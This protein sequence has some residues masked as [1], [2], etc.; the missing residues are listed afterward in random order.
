MAMSS[1]FSFPNPLIF[2]QDKCKRR[3]QCA[4]S[5]IFIFENQFYG[6]DRTKQLS[7][8]WGSAAMAAL[9][10]TPL[11]L[12]RGLPE[13]P[14]P[15]FPCFFSVLSGIST[16]MGSRGTYYNVEHIQ[17]QEDTLDEHL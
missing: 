4:G 17:V 9:F 8:G 11:D 1:A 6:K 3:I 16:A 14:F 10:L 13:C 7:S 15:N 5:I 12:P 2:L